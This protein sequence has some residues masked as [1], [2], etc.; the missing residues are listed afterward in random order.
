[1]SN[2]TSKLQ[3]LDLIAKLYF[4]KTT[5]YTVQEIQYLITGDSI[6]NY[7]DTDADTERE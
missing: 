7:T 4:Y 5:A 6:L 2:N 3:N 1:M